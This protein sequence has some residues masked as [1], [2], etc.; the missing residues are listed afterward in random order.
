M[1]RQNS[2]VALF[3]A[4]QPIAI[5]ENETGLGKDTLRVWE[6][7]Y[8]FPTPERDAQGER[9][10]APAQIERLLHIKRALDAGMR[11]GQ[12]VPLSLPELQARLNDHHPI[13]HHPETEA[14]W[15]LVVAGHANALAQALTM[16]QQRMGWV[17]FVNECVA[18]LNVRV[19]Q[20]WLNGEIEIHQEHVYAETL[21][22]F[23]RQSIAQLKQQGP[24]QAPKVLLT[25]LNNEQHSLGL[26]MVELMLVLV[27]CD[28]LSLGTRLPMEHVMAATRMHQPD[29]VALSFSSH[30]GSREAWRDAQTLR[31]HLPEPVAL[32]VGGAALNAPKRSPKLKGVQRMA[33]LSDLHTAAQVWRQTQVRT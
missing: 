9:L 33:S 11:P 12:V 22:T 1:I 30:Y 29:V 3:C 31:S 28:T 19:G 13:D 20:A 2:P 4:P 25:T 21:Q 8:G 27:R 23:L 5:V 18:P 16:T 17:A 26:L 6:K 10:Y 32:W 15:P 7:R 14:L 24:L